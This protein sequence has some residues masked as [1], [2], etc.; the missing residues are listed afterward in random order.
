ME[1]GLDVSV[2]RDR[3]LKDRIQCAAQGPATEAEP[4]LGLMRGEL[5]RRL[6][7]RHEA[8]G[9]EPGRSGGV[10][11]PTRPTLPGGSGAVELPPTG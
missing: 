9:D 7:A 6:R 8:G 1:D 10:R 4:G 3:E 2:L 11:E 5:I